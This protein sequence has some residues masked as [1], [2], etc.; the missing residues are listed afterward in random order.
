MSFEIKPTGWIPLDIS[1]GTL[2][3]EVEKN[4]TLS[5]VNLK[6]EK[7][8]RNSQDVPKELSVDSKIKILD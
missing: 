5:I 8:N 6:K 1:Y 7:P 3:C 4:L 2:K